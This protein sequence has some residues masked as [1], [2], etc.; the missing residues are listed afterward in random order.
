MQYTKH[1]HIL[2]ESLSFTIILFYCL[3]NIML[4][5]KLKRIRQIGM[6]HTLRLLEMH[7]CL[8]L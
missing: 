8:S 5:V 1:N 6:Q 2:W 3:T 4:F 7:V